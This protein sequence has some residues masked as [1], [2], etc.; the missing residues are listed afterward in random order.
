MAIC[1]ML[2][3]VQTGKLEMN[4]FIIQTEGTMV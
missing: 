3:E 1:E 2:L 4:T